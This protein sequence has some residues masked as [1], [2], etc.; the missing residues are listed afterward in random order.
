L[1]PRAPTVLL[2]LG[3]AIA[4]A[5]CGVGEIG[6]QSSELFETAPWTG[7]ET[8]SY[9][10]SQRGNDL[11][12]TCTLETRPGSDGTTTLNRLCADPEG[13]SRDDAT[14]TVD[15]ASLRPSSAQRT[16]V[17]SDGKR[18][19]FT[20]TYHEADVRFVANVDG[21]ENQA[22]RDLPQ[23]GEDGPDPGWYDDESLLW[24]VR[25]IPL[26]R[27]FEGVYHNVNA[28]TGRVFKVRLTVENLEQVTVPAGT[29]Q[30]W[31]I[32]VETASVTQ[33]I[34]VEAEA[35]H[36]VVRARIERVFYEL[37]SGS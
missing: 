37:V 5:A 16:I 9:N 21:K 30:A 8:L 34:W 20:S 33:R 24:L 6:G 12:G 7:P 14:V 31:N 15:T 23:P 2:A 17:R 11:Y 28:S 19:T 4:L 32:K 18:S 36:R 10:M 29:F 13:K 26:A 27:G 25:G 22:I 35:P 1:T 3:A